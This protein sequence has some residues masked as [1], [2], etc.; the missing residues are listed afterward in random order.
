[1]RKSNENEI[2]CHMCHMIDHMINVINRKNNRE[3]ED[4]L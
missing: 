4:D 1:M 2:T 3:A